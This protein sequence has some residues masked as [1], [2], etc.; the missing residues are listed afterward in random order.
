[1]ALTSRERRELFSETKERL[2]QVI[3]A[4]G[5]AEELVR[6]T[7]QI[8]QGSKKLVVGTPEGLRTRSTATLADFVIAAKKIAQ[9]TRAVDAASLQKLSSTRKA[10]DLLLDEL[11]AWHSSQGSGRDEVDL[12]LEDFLGKAPDNCSSN[13]SG[14]SSGGGVGNRTSPTDRPSSTGNAMVMSEHER[15]LLAELKS[16]QEELARK[17]E[18][19]NYPT[20]LQGRAEDTLQMVVSGLSRSTSQLMDQAGQRSP[21]KESM[22]ESTIT[23][24]RLICI[25]LD[26]VDNLF[27]S[28]YPMRP[29]VSQT[30][31]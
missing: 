17:K 11:D 28:K 25:L 20:P 2:A 21:N 26:V 8:V 22:I 5:K 30:L 6:L 15:R 1:M 27:V 24:A 23:V 13:S 29:Q 14:V 12:M 31:S 10:V 3:G 4:S 9:D 19:Q 16:R 18:P 7:T